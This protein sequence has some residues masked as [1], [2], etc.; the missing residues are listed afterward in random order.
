VYFHLSTVLSL[1]QNNLPR[2]WIYVTC[3]QQT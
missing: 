2:H 1:T 3:R